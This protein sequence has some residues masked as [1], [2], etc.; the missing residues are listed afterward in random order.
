MQ[1]PEL[2]NSIE[3]NFDGIPDD[4]KNFDAWVVWRFEN[5][6]GDMKKP[7][8]NPRTG[9][10]ASVVSPA[11]WGSFDEARK[12]Y[13][14]GEWAGVGF[15]LTQGIVGVDIDHCIH[16]GSVTPDALS[17]IS[18]LDTYTELSPT[19]PRGEKHPMG[20]HLWLKKVVLPGR[21]RKS[22]N[23]EMYQDRRYITVTGHSLREEKAQLSDDQARLASV[24]H[25]V[26]VYADESAGEENRRL[27]GVK[28]EAR[29]FTYVTN[30]QALDRGYKAA[31][32][33]NFMRH[34]EGDIS[35]W[36]GAGA[37]YASQ[38]NAD[39]VLVLFLLRVT[40]GDAAQ[41][42]RLFRRSGLMRSK[43]DRPVRGSETY[44]NY[45]IRKAKEVAFNK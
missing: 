36:E 11:T 25:E 6:E 13:E 45:T 22:G 19:I 42:D 15:V 3:V 39:F 26:F 34:Y 21:Y 23:I 30:E 27:G 37:K 35:L 2:P 4:L 8:F 33:A 28:K 18:A 29:Y 44:G 20:V 32:G 31:N 5:V 1:Q 41:V 12:A 17:I 10:R 16:E 9:K 38:S 7:P 14:T 40:N 43:W 24:Y